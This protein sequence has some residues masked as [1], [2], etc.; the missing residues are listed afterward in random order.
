VSLARLLGMTRPAV[1]IYGSGGFTAYSLEQLG[2]QLAGWVG[3]G[4][5]RVKMKVGRSPQDDLERVRYARQCIGDE[6]ELFVDAN[7]AYSRKSA[8]GFAYQFAELGVTWFEEPVPSDDLDGLRLL[9]DRSPPGMEIT[10]GEYGYQLIDFQRLLASGAVDCLQADVTRCGGI[11]GFLEAA[12]VCSAYQIPLSSHCAPSLHVAACCSA[13][14]ARHIEYF[15]D[16]VR[17][18][19]LLFDG[20]LQPHSGHLKPDC[21]KPGLGLELKWADARQYQVEVW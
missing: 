21:S 10:A 3:Q 14:C 2:E 11:S 9:R 13:P 12:A 19:R 4:I 8:L 17:I 15:F 16:H 18:E 5:P 6:A 1:A 7:G 20:A